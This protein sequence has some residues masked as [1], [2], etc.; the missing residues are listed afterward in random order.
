[1]ADRVQIELEQKRNARE[2]F[3]D[4]NVPTPG[5]PSFMLPNLEPSF[6]RV[7]LDYWIA[8]ARAVTA[9]LPVLDAVFTTSHV[10]A[11]FTNL[12][13][14]RRLRAKVEGGLFVADADIRAIWAAVGGAATTGFAIESTP[15][16]WTLIKESVAEAVAELPNTLAG[17][18]II[19]DLL[20][21]GAIAIGAVLLLQITND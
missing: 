11:Y 18:P 21:F 16:P 12:D 5:R 2:L 4:S 14:M 17:L 8:D 7:L 1:M 19:G 6:A 13:T 9:A 3:G 20:K 15:T 10:E